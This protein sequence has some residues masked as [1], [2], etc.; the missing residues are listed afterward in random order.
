[1]FPESSNVIGNHRGGFCFGGRVALLRL[2][3]GDG[4]VGGK[5]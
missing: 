2:A 5:W 4:R 1:M 3:R